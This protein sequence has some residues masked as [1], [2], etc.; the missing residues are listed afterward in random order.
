[1]ILGTDISHWEDNP[2]TPQKINFVK[3]KA[4]GAWFCIFKATQALYTDSVFKSSWADC[5]GLM[6]RGAYHYLD[7]TKPGLEQAKYFCNAIAADP[8]E[9]PPVVDYECRTNIPPDANGQLWNFVSYVEA[10]TK[11]API[12]YTGP[13]Y[14][15]NYGSGNV[16]WKKFP[17]WIANYQV[18]KPYVPAPWTDW[19]FWQFTDRGQGNIYGA[20]AL[21]IDL[22]YYNGT[23]EQL[24]ALCNI[25]TPPPVLTL[26]QR[27]TALE[28]AARKAG[29]IL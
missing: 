2:L 7:W 19:T 3:M 9:L 22:N 25:S 18:T 14:W 28:V 10:V 24:Q 27:V 1:M 5:K 8:P 15:K 21:G 16:G 12:I 6:P 26:E 4:A 17:L 29:W 23:I 20:E 11:R 13:D